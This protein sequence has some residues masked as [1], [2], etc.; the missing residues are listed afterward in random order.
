MIDFFFLILAKLSHT[1]SF[2]SW[3]SAWLKNPPLIQTLKLCQARYLRY[4]ECHLEKINK[5]IKIG[6]WEWWL[7]FGSAHKDN[8]STGGTLLTKNYSKTLPVEQADL[9]VSFFQQTSSGAGMDTELWKFRDCWCSLERFPYAGFN[10]CL[11][12]QATIC[13]FLT[14]VLLVMP[15]TANTIP[16]PIFTN[17]LSASSFP[18]AVKAFDKTE[19]QILSG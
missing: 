18:A 6:I 9:S 8:V 3:R 16:A 7:P 1:S 14:P 5:Y 2:Y 11:R 12:F 4:T 15:A 19:G 10:P 17:L 13:S